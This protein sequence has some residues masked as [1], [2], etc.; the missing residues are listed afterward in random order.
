M[1]LLRDCLFF[2]M[3]SFDQF[4]LLLWILK[5][6]KLK[7][8]RKHHLKTSKKTTDAFMLQM[9]YSR[10]LLSG[11]SHIYGRQGAVAGQF[12]PSFILALPDL[13]GFKEFVS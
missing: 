9:Q 3:F 11:I 6:L 5:S 8:F 4:E 2:P 12:S 13:F 10:E 1:S 7:V